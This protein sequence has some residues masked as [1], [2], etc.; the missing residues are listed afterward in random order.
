M[1]EH[2]VEGKIRI[3]TRPLVS[4]VVEMIGMQNTSLHTAMVSPQLRCK[5]G[6]KRS[7]KAHESGIISCILVYSLTLVP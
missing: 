7:S 1:Q 4:R 3:H 5:P 6:L 2:E